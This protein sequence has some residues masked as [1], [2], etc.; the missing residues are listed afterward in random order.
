MPIQW[1]KCFNKKSTSYDFIFFK[2]YWKLSKIKD[3]KVYLS[4]KS[5]TARKLN[6]LVTFLIDQNGIIQSFPCTYKFKKSIS[7]FYFLRK[8]LFSNSPGL[9]IH[10]KKNTPSVLL[11]TSK[12]SKFFVPLRR[13]VS[14]FWPL[15]KC[16]PYWTT[17]CGQVKQSRSIP[18]A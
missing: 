17:S 3:F 10:G 13:S 8:W 18:L 12:L 5:I 16:S 11:K 6:F 9:T 2:K 7:N 4:R 14:W 15:S 1:L